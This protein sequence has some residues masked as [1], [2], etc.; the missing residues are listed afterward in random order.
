MFGFASTIYL[1]IEIHSSLRCSKNLFKEIFKDCCLLFSY[2]GSCHSLSNGSFNILPKHFSFVKNFFLFCYFFFASPFWVSS[3]ILALFVLSCQDISK[4]FLQ[5][6]SLFLTFPNT[7]FHLYLMLYTLDME[8]T[9]K[10]GF[11]P[12]RR[13]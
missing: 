3:N 9:E 6:F 4:S 8:Q 10:E 11:E 1:Y 5:N 12:S 2:Q 7:V 13:Y